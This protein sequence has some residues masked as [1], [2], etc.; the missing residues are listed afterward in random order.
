M[1]ELVI[2]FDRELFSDHAVLAACY[3]YL[4]DLFFEV[5]SNNTKVLL[6]ISRKDLVG[7]FNKSLI[8]S[9]IRNS[10]I[11]HE[12]RI[13][14]ENKT[15]KIKETLIYAALSESGLNNI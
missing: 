2:E 11:D 8:E 9:E 5:T 1:S 10:V 6:S 4:E 13:R 3:D 12:L 7:V 14:V 15:K